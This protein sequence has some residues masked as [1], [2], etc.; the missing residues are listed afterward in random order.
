MEHELTDDMGLI[1]VEVAGEEVI[2]AGSG[3]LSVDARWASITPPDH[4]Y[5]VC[6]D[7]VSLQG[8][9]AQSECWPLDANRLTSLWQANEV[10]RGEYDLRADPFL[11]GGEHTLALS[12]VDQRSGMELGSSVTLGE[13]EV[14]ALQRNFAEA[15]PSQVVQVWFGETILLHGYDLQSSADSLEL[16]LYWQAGRRVDQSYKVFVHLVDPF[17]DSTVTQSDSVP[18]QWTYPT[19]WW[20]SG[21]VVE[22]PVTLSLEGVPSGRYMLVVG[23]YEEDT[24]ER[25]AALSHEGEQYLGDSVTLTEVER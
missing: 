25:L 15:A 23:L 8:E 24:G 11:A 17:T 10:V 18:R 4:D 1:R 16:V 9:R 20:E 21:E 2:Q 6:L 7:L 5:E 14:E 13:L 3:V 19:H 22:D 12:L